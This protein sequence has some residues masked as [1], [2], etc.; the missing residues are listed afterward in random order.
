MIS[1]KHLVDFRGDLLVQLETDVSA[2]Q[3]DVGI[4]TS[5]SNTAI[6]GR[7]RSYHDG[8]LNSAHPYC[9]A[10]T[11]KTIG[12]AIMAPTPQQTELFSSSILMLR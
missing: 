6:S 10:M 8:T 12:R 3:L 9:W 11:S 1:A 2:R 4:S 7:S 5:C